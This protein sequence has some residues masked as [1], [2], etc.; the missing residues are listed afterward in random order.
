L[1]S[2]RKRLLIW[3]TSA[4]VL[5]ALLV[6][7]ITYQLA[8]DGFNRMRDFALEQ[9]AYSILQYGVEP[10]GSPHDVQFVSQIWDTNGK[11]RFTSRQDL[12]LPLLQPGLHTLERQGEEWH[13]YTLVSSEATVQVANTGANRNLMFAEISPW[14]LLP[15]ILLVLVLGGLLS[16][17][18]HKALQPLAAIREGILTQDIAH[19]R[20]LPQAD[21]PNE[22][23]P[24]VD[25]LNSLL[26]RLE[27]VL[28]AKRRFVA[29]AAHELRTPLA[30]IKLQT[31]VLRANLDES[32]RNESLALLQDSVDRATRLAGQL[33]QLARLDPDVIKPDAPDP[34]AFDRIARQMVAEFSGRAESLGIDLGLARCDPVQ[35]IA[36]P[37]D[38][39]GLLANLIDNALRYGK[40]AGHVDIEIS[41]TQDGRCVLRVVD[42]G[43]G[44]PDA[45]KPRV[46]ERFHRLASADIPGSGLG[47]AI[48]REVVSRLDGRIAL[49]NTPDGGLTVT[50]ELPLAG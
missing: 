32:Q 5:A 6:S 3:Q 48:V 13:I 50:V 36:S 30:A 22:V 21:Y 29:D 25:A 11:L 1:N 38:L 9:I 43:P 33:L 17:A 4:F 40:P 24:L 46:F 42:D 39:H 16:L 10:I 26:T 28:S 15:L 18:M 31:Q 47:L 14:L 27:G 45:E 8:W 44:I 41:A 2:I 37:E 49:E 34:V 35:V 19:L 23:A 7:L 20:T 12:D